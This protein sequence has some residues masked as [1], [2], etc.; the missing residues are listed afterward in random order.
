MAVSQADA[1]LWPQLCCQAGRSHLLDCPKDRLGWLVYSEAMWLFL[2]IDTSLLPG[3][4]EGQESSTFK[5][6]WLLAHSSKGGSKGIR[7]WNGSGWSLD[8]GMWRERERE[9]WGC[10]L[11]NALESSKEWCLALL[12]LS[13]N[14]QREWR[15]QMPKRHWRI[16][17]PE[18]MGDSNG[19][20]SCAR[21]FGGALA[22]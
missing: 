22:T 17:C 5:W 18:G 2:V 14:W 20:H 4:N 19:I 12:D 21:G 7:L 11:Q 6:P 15:Y 10:K 9:K 8:Y 13:P 16:C 1:T 3:I